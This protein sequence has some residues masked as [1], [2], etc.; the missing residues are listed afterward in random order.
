MFVSFKK[1]ICLIIGWLFLVNLSLAAQITVVSYGGA[2]TKAQEQAFYLPFI[3]E[4]IHIIDS[5]IY[6][7]SLNAI[8][9]AGTNWH[10]IEVEG[11][12][13]VRGCDAGIFEQLSMRNMQINSNKLIKGAV[14]ACGLGFFVYSN[15]LAYN[16]EKLSSKP[17]SWQDFWD[18]KKFPGKRS[19]R[20]H[21]KTTL[22]F[23]LLADGVIAADLYKI[24]ATK[25]GQDRAFAK[26]DEL[27]EHII[28]WQTGQQAADYLASGK[29][30]MGSIYNGR[31]TDAN[32][33]FIWRDALYEFEYWAIAKGSKNQ[34]ASH[35]FMRFSVTDEAQKRFMQNINYG[36]TNKKALNLIEKDIAHKLPT[37]ND[38]LAKQIPIDLYFWVD[39]GTKLEE[40]F[41]QWLVQ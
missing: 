9:A 26:L 20:K 1:N 5:Q 13:L 14:N 24:L 10:V 25:E 33:D 29:A 36:A 22:E 11:A 12:E 35:D 4:S 7:G 40:R 2:N 38:N 18:V 32:I 6:D 19:L 31:I 30:I 28:W 15:V 39:N 3:K 34:N 8:T 23:A 27:K 41:N 17:N 16:A 21:P 37:A